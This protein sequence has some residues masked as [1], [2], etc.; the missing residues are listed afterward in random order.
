LNF[1]V[2]NPV[3]TNLK[4]FIEGASENGELISEIKTLIMNDE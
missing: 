3:S 2:Y 4:L 1:T